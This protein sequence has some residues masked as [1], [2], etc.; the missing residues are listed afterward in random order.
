MMSANSANIDVQDVRLQIAEAALAQKQTSVALTIIR[1]GLEDPTDQDHLLR[2]TF[3]LGRNQIYKE[4]AT[5]WQRL[6][7]QLKTDDPVALQY[8]DKAKENLAA[9]TAETQE[10]D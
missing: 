3:L 10:P 9:P 4:A 7:Q 6:L 8:L 1:R 5:I 2:Y